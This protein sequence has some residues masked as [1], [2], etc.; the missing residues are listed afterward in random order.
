VTLKAR[1]LV[2]ETATFRDDRLFI[3]AC[4]DTYVP[5]QYFDLLE[6]PRVQIHVIPTAHG[7]SSP[8]HV[9]ERLLTFDHAE[10]DERWLLL[11]IDHRHAGPHVRG[12]AQTLSE[13]RRQGVNSAICNPCFELW[14]LL[15]FKDGSEC[16]RFGDCADVEGALREALGGYNKRRLQSG[17]FTRRSV[18]DACARA[19]RLGQSAPWSIPEGCS[20]QVQL[21]NFQRNSGICSPEE[22]PDGVPPRGL[23]CDS[24]TAG[25]DRNSATRNAAR[26][27]G[28]R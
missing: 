1:P 27:R 28:E 22:C 19:R 13:A 5:K 24:I 2:R 25:S 14:L 6:I 20:A 9:L 23:I 21:T 4:E 11:D 10:Y 26:K 8:P 18:A 12:L 17:Q 16:D 15:H 3:V 7:R